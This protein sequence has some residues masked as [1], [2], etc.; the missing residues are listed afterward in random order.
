MNLDIHDGIFLSMIFS[1][2][3]YV[4]SV[5]LIAFMGNPFLFFYVNSAFIS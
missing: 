3:L 4:D 5:Y 1:F 2:F